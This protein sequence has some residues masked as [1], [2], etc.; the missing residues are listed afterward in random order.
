[1][2][3]KL[4]S[5]PYYLMHSANKSILFGRTDVILDSGL[6]AETDQ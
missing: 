4:I 6:L 1:M 3:P 2:Y 5:A